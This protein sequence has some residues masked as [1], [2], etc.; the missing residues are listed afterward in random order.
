MICN[1]CG[2]TIDPLNK[3]C[4][5]CGAPMQPVSPPM[6]SGPSYTPPGPS[7][8]PP[9]PTYTPPQMPGGPSVPPQRK[10]SCGKIIL[11]VGI[12]LLL[13]AGAIAA[14]IYF[15]YRYLDNTLRTSEPYTI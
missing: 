14:A 1:N 8:P 4:P 10:S 3:F 7:Y 9:G 15:G 11:I 13:L 6:G 2:N 5:K 12:I